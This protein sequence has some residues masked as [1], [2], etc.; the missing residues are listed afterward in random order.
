MKNNKLELKDNLQFWI[1]ATPFHVNKEGFEWY[2]HKS[3][4]EWATRKAKP[5]SFET[6]VNAVCFLVV[7]DD[8]PQGFA[9]VAPNN[10]MLG[11][12]ESQEGMANLIDTLRLVSS[13]KNK[14]DENI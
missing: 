12:H 4:T 14:K 11:E 5:G 8:E 3:L 1:N 7:K 10:T 13:T 9:L 2:V 6:P